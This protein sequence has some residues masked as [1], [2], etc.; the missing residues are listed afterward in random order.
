MVYVIIYD[1][2]HP[3]IRMQFSLNNS[4]HCRL[5]RFLDATYGPKYHNSEIFGE[6]L[7]INDTTVIPSLFNAEW[8][9]QEFLIGYD[10]NYY[11]TS[12]V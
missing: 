5:L 10:P 1:A 12:Y 4:D 6:L 3:D 8:E 11:M 2:Q 9:Q 7:D